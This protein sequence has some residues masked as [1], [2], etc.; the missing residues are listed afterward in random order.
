MSGREEEV[1]L[2]G[3]WSSPYR[4]RV[5]L[6]L[7]FKS[8][9]FQFIEE[10][11]SNK[12]P[13]LLLPIHKKI[14]VRIHNG[15]PISELLIISV[16]ADEDQQQRRGQSFDK[17]NLL[18][19]PPQKKKFAT[20]TT[21]P[22]PDATE[23]QSSKPSKSFWGFK[24]STSLNNYDLKKTLISSLPPLLTR[25]KSTGLVPVPRNRLRRMKF[26]TTG[27]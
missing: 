3:T 16:A 14:P 8:I 6:A 23:D 27:N 17:L 25:S 5:E 18:P 19:P 12:S 4:A 20:I 1:K 10:D 13:L 15:N 26:T 2:L 11:L 22:P 7:R 24:R 9:P 21:T